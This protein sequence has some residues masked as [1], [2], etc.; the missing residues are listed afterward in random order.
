MKNQWIN[1]IA[2]ANKRATKI[3]EQ[4][5]KTTTKQITS[6][7]NKKQSKWEHPDT[8]KHSTQQII[9]NQSKKLTKTNDQINIKSVTKQAIKQKTS[10]KS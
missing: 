2:S 3:R 5:R 6:R 9:T 7:S 10:N 4:K 8:Q 1:H